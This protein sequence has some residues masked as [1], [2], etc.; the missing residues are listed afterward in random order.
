MQADGTGA[1]V[2]D[3]C[4]ANQHIRERLKISFWISKAQG[5]WIWW[6]ALWIGY[7][8]WSNTTCR[9]WHLSGSNILTLGKLKLHKLYKLVAMFGEI[10]SLV[11]LGENNKKNNNI[12]FP[13]ELVKTISVKKTFPLRGQSWCLVSFLQKKMAFWSLTWGKICFRYH[14]KY[15]IIYFSVYLPRNLQNTLT[16]FFFS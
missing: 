3:N 16:W 8:K 9:V 11:K 1:A 14:W 15:I 10:Y 6:V 4:E 2:S 7:I 12:K 5:G 13:S